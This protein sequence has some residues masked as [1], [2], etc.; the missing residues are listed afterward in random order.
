MPKLSFISNYYNYPEKVEEQISYWESFPESFL[1]EVEFI[2]IDDC[3][4]QRVAFR[5]TTL[6]LRVFR[7][8]TAIAW[9]Q[10]G[11][12]NLGACNANGE[13]SLFSD[14]D[15]RFYLQPMQKLLT[16]LNNLDPMFIYYPKAKNITDLDGSPKSVHVNTILVNT[17][18]FKEMGL[19]D[20]DFAGH[21]G[22]EDLYLPE[23][24]ER[25]GGYRAILGDMEY[26]EDL[27][28]R[29]KTLDRDLTRNHMLKEEKT[30]AGAKNAPGILRFDWEAV[31][32]KPSPAD[33][34]KDLPRS[35]ALQPAGRSLLIEG[36]RG[37]NQ[38]YAL[39][40]QHQ[41][42][43]LLD[44]NG[45]QLFH[46]D[47]P[48]AFDWNAARNNPG[49]SSEDR[50]R[51]MTVPDPGAAK[52]DAV[53]RIA[54]PFRAGEKSDHR[55]TATFMVTELGLIETCFVEESLGSDFFTRDEN[56]IVT[57]SAWARERIIEFGFAPEKVQVVPHGVDLR[58]F[59]PPAPDE[60]RQCRAN[61]GVHEDEIVF[62]NVG[63]CLWN[64]GIDLLLRA[65]AV[66]RGQ[67]RPV[68]LILKDQRDVYGISVETILQEVTQTCPAL[69]EAETLRGITVIPGNL[70]QVQLRLL[71]GIG[72]CYVSPYRAEGFNLPVLEAIACGLPIIVTEGGATDDYC[73]DDVAWRMFARP[74]SRAAPGS[75]KLYRFREPD[76]D[77][78]V[79]AMSAVTHRFRPDAQRYA[80][81]RRQILHDFTWQR[82][83]ADVARLTVGH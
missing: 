29:T 72:D 14:I 19:Y 39:V 49:F 58:V 9:N 67:G 18:K 28:F 77:D 42:L 27:R 30:A 64:K 51:I 80:V 12:R 65:F 17:Q 75:E 40:N 54:S 15:Q 33:T 45:L 83:A 4:E 48:F 74:G 82:A 46:R 13:W 16:R 70:D 31:S 41:I 6:N 57:P 81:A 68:R 47:L 55:K 69:A 50:D 63:A 59:Y 76:F 20:E 60:R 35:D 7:I 2:L 44:I 23:V 32:L 61:L 22:Y 11:A 21:Y 53:Y 56:L 78:L 26:F 73:N 10:A 1:S 37:V 38:S 5:P 24:W 34:S 43:S 62:V 25:H 66:L 3:S 52:V 79:S 71:F 36:W 8:T